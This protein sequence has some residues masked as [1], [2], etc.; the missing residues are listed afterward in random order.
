MNS[1]DRIDLVVSHNQEASEAAL[2]IAD[3][4]E[5]RGYVAW[6]DVNAFYSPLV[7]AEK[8]IARAFSR[9]RVICLFVGEEYRDTRWCQ[10]E[11]GLGLRAEQDLSIARV[12]TVHHGDSGKSLIPS[13]LVDR[14]SF[15]YTE[16]GCQSIAKF[17]SALPDHS[18]ALARWSKSGT[19]AQG[20]LLGRLPVGERTKLV[21]EHVEFL[22]KHFALGQFEQGSKNHALLLGLVGTPPSKTPIHLSPAL[23][24]E[25]AWNWA[26]DILGKYNVRR[27]INSTPRTEEQAIGTEAVM[28]FLLLPTLFHQYLA[29]ARARRSPPF[30][31]ETEF[32][33][34]VDH[35]LCGFGLL[36]ARAGVDS[37]EAFREVGQLLSLFAEGEAG[38]SQ[39]A[40]YL[41]EHLPEIAYPENSAQRGASIYSLL[42]AS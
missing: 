20:D 36:C 3:S 15:P 30:N 7:S 26:L 14:P 10:E 38:V 37:E 6:A 22:V 17:L 18:A 11:Y 42:R 12:I 32:L 29:V 33:S 23:L 19:A 40:A 8:Q 34:V 4:V 39:S 16:A 9:A 13:P 31:T 28:P 41:R 35:V 1:P 27:L 25:L 21:V 2:R 24:M 5:E